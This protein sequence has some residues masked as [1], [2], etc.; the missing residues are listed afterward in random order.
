MNIV[1]FPE[2]RA[3]DQERVRASDAMMALL[4]GSRLAENTLRLTDGSTRL[5]PEIFPAVP[6][7]RRMN[8]TTA[9]A[10]SLLSQ[11]ERHLGAMAVPYALAI[12]EDF[13]KTCFGLLLRDGQISPAEI[14]GADASS[15]HRIFEQKVGKQLPGSSIEQYHLIRRMRNAVIH[16]GGKPKQGLVNAAKNLSSGALAQWMKVTGESPA[17]RVRLGV[18][19]TFSHGELVLALAVTKRISLEMNF[20]LRDSLSRATW[21]DVALEDFVAEHP[22]LVHIAQRKRKLTGFLRSYYQALNL[23]EVEATAAM[24]RAGW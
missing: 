4:A 2:H 16:A 12:H 9:N 6:H 5:L 8:L 21:A 15:M 11:A 3:Y 23:T 24:Q 22:R 19:V 10:R 1:H 18:P 17:A 13:V 14:R 7:I 20:A